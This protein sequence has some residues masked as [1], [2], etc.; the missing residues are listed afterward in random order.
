[1]FKIQSVIQNDTV[2]SNDLGVDKLLPKI[3]AY[4]TAGLETKCLR[5]F[6]YH[7]YTQIISISPIMKYFDYC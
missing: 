5:F 3:P 7:L 6:E 2:L 4:L 1:M